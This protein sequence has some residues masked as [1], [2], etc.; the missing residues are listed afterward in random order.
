VVE[1][2]NTGALLSGPSG[3][4]AGAITFASGISVDPTGD[5][6]VSGIQPAALIKMDGNGTLLSGPSFSLP[7]A[8]LSPVNVAT[9][10]AGNA[11]VP[12]YYGNSGTYSSIFKLASD[13]TNLSG[14]QGFGSGGLIYPTQMAI[15]AS[16]SVWVVGGLSLSV[17]K[18]DNSGVLLSGPNGYTG[19]GF[20]GGSPAP[21]FGL[22]HGGNVWVAN[23]AAPQV[24]EFSNSG[25]PVSGTNGFATCNAAL[26]APDVCSGAIP[27]AIDGSGSVWTS[28]LYR[29]FIRGTPTITGIDIVRL[30]NDGTILSGTR[31][32]SGDPASLQVD[33]SGNLW[34]IGGG[35]I[36][37][38]GVATPAVTP[39]SVAARDNKLGVRP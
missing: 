13:G 31:G 12:S 28:V 34:G 20:L 1:L 35:V 21:Q 27:L 33:S 16:G 17:A 38:V 7:P 36:E 26:V 18:F 10:G 24:A 32:Y 3:Y 4:N 30:A 5:V 29:Y 15:D 23:T 11:W 2:S 25:A 14:D 39:L 9:D 6:W 22:D 19:A 8:M 37:L